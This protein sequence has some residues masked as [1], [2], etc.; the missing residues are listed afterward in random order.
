MKRN[1]GFTLFELVITI[2]I[3]GILATLAFSFSGGLT[4]STR[5]ES[6]LRELKRTVTFARAQATATD[7]IIIICPATT[8]LVEAN[9]SFVC[10]NDWQANRIAVFLD[11]DNNGSYNTGSDDLLRVMEQVPNNDGLTFPASSLRFDSSGRTAMLQASSFVYCP[12][13]TDFPNQQLEVSVVG[14]ALYRGDTT[15]TCN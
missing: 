15:L 5:A 7:E 1:T 14:S 3:L 8:A 12:T 10:Q 11:R 6:Y 4:T 2:A 13:A 9:N